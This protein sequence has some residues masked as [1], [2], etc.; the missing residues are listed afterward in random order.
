[1]IKLTVRGDKAIMRKLKGMV[2]A[3]RKKVLTK[4]ARTAAKPLLQQARSNAPTRTGA[5]RK[6]IKLRAKKKNRRGVVGVSVAVG[7]KWFVGDEFY[8]A[9]QEFGWKAGTRPGKN[10]KEPDTRPQIEG[11]H[12]I[13]RA[14]QTGGQRALRTFMDEVPREIEKLM[15]GGGKT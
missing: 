13:E 3:A 7:A 4:A 6:A 12:Y 9:F 14:Y 5:L 1:M 2:P 10:S 15:V 8:G 11:K